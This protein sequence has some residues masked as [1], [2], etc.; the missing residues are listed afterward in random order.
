[1]KEG[2]NA[3][4]KFEVLEEVEAEDGTRSYHKVAE[5]VPIEG[6]IWDNRYMASEEGAEGAD[7]GCTTFRKVS[8]K[9]I[10][11]GMLI[12]EVK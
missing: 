12:R 5:I 1:M 4:S 9:D 8:G 11:A 3:K 10:L 6:K 7:L 2:V